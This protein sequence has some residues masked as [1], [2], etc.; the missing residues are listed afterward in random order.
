ML[1]KI[2]DPSLCIHLPKVERIIFNKS[3]ILDRALKFISYI[4]NANYFNGYK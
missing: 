2:D 3:A 4:F 1:D